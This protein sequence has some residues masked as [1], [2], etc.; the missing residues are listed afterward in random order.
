MHPT[1]CSAKAWQFSTDTRGAIALLAAAVMPI[2]IGA[3]A[4]AVDMGSLYVE[5]RQA[6]GAA[7]LAAIAAASDLEN[8]EAAVAA[9]LKANGL[10]SVDSLSV[11][12]GSYVPDPDVPIGL[13]FR[14]GASPTNAVEVVFSKPGT[15]FFARVFSSEP[16]AIEVRAVAAN[17]SL[18]TFSI[19]S[20]LLAV[21][22]GLLNKLLGAMFGGSLNLTVMDYEALIDADVKL[23]SLLN[24]LA[25]E[26][27]LTGVT[28]NEILNT[29]VTAGNVL[30]AAAAATAQEGN[31]SVAA[32]LH[33]LAGQASSATMRAPLSTLLD[34]GV[35]GSASIGQSSPGLDAGVN[36]LDLVTGIASLANETNQAALDLTAGVPGLLS[37]KA[38]L[39]IGERPQHSPWVA[40]GQPGAAVY[41][42]Q[43]RLRVVAEVGGSGLLAGARIRL[44]IG[45]DIAYAKATL[46][47]VSCSNAE[48]STAHATIAARPG[49][50]RAWVGE[51]SASSLADPSS[52]PV[53]STA[54]I[55]DLPLIKVTGRAD[56][57]SGNIGDTNLEFTHSDVDDRTV[58]T[59]GTRN[60]VET[61]VTSLLG[62]LQLTVQLGGLGIGLPGP[63]TQLVMGALGAIAPALDQAIYELLNTLGVHLGEAD[64]R[65]HGI[66]C[67]TSVLA[68]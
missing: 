42:A 49:V 22:A 53:V 48:Q 1:F 56:I 29:K 23:L 54:R 36:A 34:L 9:T 12:K 63:I 55:V 28:Y 58:K 5:R 2:A 14:P 60:F 21:R 18:A 8:A 50:A 57:A 51:L 47:E 7:D 45:I 37:L 6:Q 68:G 16:I 25:T 66:R 30:S 41:T 67:G 61:L 27:N 19:G 3:L 44:P 33:T 38:D 24:A 13:R 52:E 26:L 15:T 59:V 10:A 46:S 35:I 11:T 31:A 43:T 20:R 40:M 17:A 4:L 65:V 32:V 64:V 39:A 62:K